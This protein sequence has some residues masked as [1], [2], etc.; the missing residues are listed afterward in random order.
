MPNSA[1]AATSLSDDSLVKIKFDQKLSNQLSLDLTFRDEAGTGSARRL[2]REEAGH[3][4]PRLLRLPDALHLVL[5]GMVESLQDLKLDIGNQFEVINV[6]ID[7]NET[8]ELA[9]AK[10]RTYLKRY[11]R[12]G[13]AAGWHFLTGD[14]PAIKQLARSG[15]PLRLRS[16]HQAIRAS[17]RHHRADARGQGGAL[18]LRD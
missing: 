11:G 5:N 1:P 16:E 18:L 2:L 10:K 13:A 6:S 14:E 8:P 15:L 9:A 7:P 4:R 3:S 12:P 17:Q